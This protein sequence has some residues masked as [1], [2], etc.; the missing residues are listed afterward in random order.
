MRGGFSW[1]VLVPIIAES[2]EGL[3]EFLVVVWIKEQQ[4]PFG[5]DNQKGNSKGND[6]DKAGD[7]FCCRPLL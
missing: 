3:A 4:I 7:S 1:D 6:N 2:C 5:D